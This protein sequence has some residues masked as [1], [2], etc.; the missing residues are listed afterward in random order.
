MPWFIPILIFFARICDV[1]IGTIR[2][3]LIIRGKPL[4]SALMGFLEVSIWVMAIAGTLKYLSNPLALIAYA[5][6][7]ASG[8]IIG[9]YLEK[10]FVT[11]YQTVRVINTDE[12]IVLADHLRGKGFPV[13][14]VDGK[15]KEPGL[16]GML[17]I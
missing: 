4:I 9:M 3:I 12:Q 15:G 13:T 2:I 17:L 10:H 16:T 8:I 5:S 11:R 6:G 1:S 7:F 14:C